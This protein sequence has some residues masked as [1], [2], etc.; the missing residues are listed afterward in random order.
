MRKVQ[1]I[2]ESDL[3]EIFAVVVFVEKWFDQYFSAKILSEIWVN[4]F[5][6]NH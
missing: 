5:L 2:I 4:N 1:D 3:S 6:P